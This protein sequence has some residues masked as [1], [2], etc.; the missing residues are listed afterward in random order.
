MVESKPE[1]DKTPRTIYGY[2]NGQWPI[3]ARVVKKLHE[4]ELAK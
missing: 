3:S 2:E 4:M 1:T